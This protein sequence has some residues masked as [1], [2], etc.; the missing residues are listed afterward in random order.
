MARFSAHFLNCDA[1]ELLMSK[2]AKP[3]ININHYLPFLIVG[4]LNRVIVMLF[5]VYVLAKAGTG[6]LLYVPLIG[7]LCGLGII[8]TRVINSEKCQA[9]V[10]RIRG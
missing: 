2:L 3:Y 8:V 5:L 6:D 4:M 1:Y 9:C 7:V 10:N